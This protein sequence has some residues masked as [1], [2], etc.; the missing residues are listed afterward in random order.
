MDLI[1]YA[2]Q[3]GVAEIRLDRPEKLNA[4]TPTMASELHRLARCANDDDVVKA[5]LLT[6]AGNSA[7]CAGSDLQSLADY[8]NEWAF[9]NRCEYA[10]AIRDIRK[11]VVAALKGWVL[12]G[13]A[14]MALAADI[15]VADETM[16]LGFPEV[17]HGWV[18]G[19]G[20]LAIAAS[21]LRLR[22]GDES[23]THRKED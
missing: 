13:G 16:R 1:H 5:V 17:S 19:G 23:A 22:P 8:A 14:E 10:A 2:V 21:A 11:P 15:R 4:M 12:G 3:D 9:R 20:G 7:F 6:G 18:G